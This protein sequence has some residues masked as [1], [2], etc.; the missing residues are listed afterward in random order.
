MRNGGVF[1]KMSTKKYVFLDKEFTSYQEIAE[2]FS[3]NWEDAIKVINDGSFLK[4][5][6]EVDKLMYGKVDL[7]IKRCR[8][9]DN[10]LT[11]TI[12]SLDSTK[13][14]YLRD[15]YFEDF[16]S[17]ATI[18]RDSFPEVNPLLKNFF[19]DKCVSYLFM[20]LEFASEDEKKCWALIQQI[21]EYSK[22]D[23]IYL[24][25]QCL[26]DPED[27]QMEV[28][29]N[30]PTKVEYY[31]QHT[32]N[33]VKDA[34]A[35]IKQL[36][37]DNLFLSYLI[38]E[39]GI[40]NVIEYK[41]NPD[42]YF[43]GLIDLIKNYTIFDLKP[44]LLVGP[45]MWMLEN[46]TNYIFKGK[47]SKNILKKYQNMPSLKDVE[48]KED[49]DA[50]I[51]INKEALHLY[52]EMSQYFVRNALVK[53]RYDGVM[54]STL[55]YYLSYD[56]VS[57]QVCRQYLLEDV[58]ADEPSLTMSH[59]VEQEK[60]YLIYETNKT[61]EMNEKK[62]EK[63][64]YDE[65]YTAAKGCLNGQF[66]FA[67]VMM[68]VSLFVFYWH[69]V[70]TENLQKLIEDFNNLDLIDSLIISLSG[71]AFVVSF[72][73]NCN[74]LIKSSKVSKIARGKF[75]AKRL[76]EIVLT[77]TEYEVEENNVSFSKPV[78]D[79]LTKKYDDN[80]ICIDYVNKDEL[81]MQYAHSKS[82]KI[83]NS[84]ILILI[85][86]PMLFVFVD[87]FVMLADKDILSFISNFD[88][89]AYNLGS[90]IDLA[91]AL[92]IALIIVIFKRKKNFISLIMMI[93]FSVIIMIAS[94]YLQ[95]FIK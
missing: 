61:I 38:I 55:D 34:F 40:E 26:I 94:G 92:G 45:H 50:I 7:S 14:F 5:L 16:T 41:S 24:F 20:P 1:M 46:Y 68:L 86:A 81:Y 48:K 19:I 60:K 70:R 35:S 63:N 17:F 72:I 21:E 56:Y 69:G 73:C 58:L 54:S 78:V 36:S 29:Y 10:A 79:V 11:M 8:F 9:I 42:N 80:L 15:L 49:I 3:K 13:G 39:C 53:R 90:Y 51:S 27:T 91:I 85:S 59:F 12:Y 57:M 83:L 74:T 67:L 2:A 93:I 28:G 64:L 43:Y 47:T 77:I 87:F 44:L 23:Y 22:F 52:I 37:E 62:K 31:L 71:L 95:F 33:D 84:L 6:N 66:I 75:N 32:L 88:D 82:N 89:V 65:N 30:A 18:V 76:E 4:Y 25:F